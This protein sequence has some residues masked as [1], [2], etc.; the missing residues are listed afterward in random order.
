MKTHGV[1]FIR[2]PETIHHCSRTDTLGEVTQPDFT[3]TEDGFGWYRNKQEKEGAS[4]PYTQTQTYVQHR[5][6]RRVVASIP[7]KP[8][9][10]VSNI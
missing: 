6:A 3:S 5:T 8:Y 10:I 9:T 7:A 2:A 1:S 4:K